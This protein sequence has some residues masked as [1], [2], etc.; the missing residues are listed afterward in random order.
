MTYEKLKDHKKRKK[1]KLFLKNNS[2]TINVEDQNIIK[3]KNEILEIAK[4]GCY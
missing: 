4:Y 3:Y 1:H 2:F